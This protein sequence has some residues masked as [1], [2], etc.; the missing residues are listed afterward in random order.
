MGNCVRKES[1]MQW[2]GEDWG[3]PVL[4]SE[5][6]LSS[7]EGHEKRQ[8]YGNATKIEEESRLLGSNKGKGDSDSP[9]SSSSP[10]TETATE[11][12]IKI[13]KKQLEELL[14]RMDVEGISVQQLLVQL[15]SASDRYETHQRSWRPAL[16]SI[17]EAS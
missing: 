13:T 9:F 12:K 7:D 17:P 5:T 8:I 4:E 2:A 15:I 3:S 16:Q 6:L 10:T 11:V 1:P 14:G